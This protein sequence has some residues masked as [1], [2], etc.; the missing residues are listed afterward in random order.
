MSQWRHRVD[1][2]LNTIDAA[3]HA[4]I[5]AAAAA[6]AASLRHGGIVQTFATGHS[7]SV[8]LEFAGR[9]GGFV[10]A[11]Q[12]GIR[13]L[14]Y[15]GQTPLQELIDPKIEREHGLAS[16]IL[17]LA[18]IKPADIFVIIS[19]SGRN[20]TVVEMAREVISRGHRLIAITSRRPD[21]D[22]S[23]EN[24]LAALADIV[25]DTHG[26][27]GDTALETPLGRAC[28]T[29]TLA[30]IYV[31]HALTAATVQCIA[32]AGGTTDLLVSSNWPGGDERNAERVAVFG[33][34]VRWGDA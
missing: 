4:A 24:Y 20:A 15:Y 25:I 26:D 12:L 1:T 18:T 8:A 28:A 33:D 7:R 23:M 5:A 2:L 16:Q 19:N 14:A 3:E 29:S 22:S 30:G 17:S 34:R 32:D 21:G 13:D 27:D 31:V 10:A 11:N 9:A 6:I